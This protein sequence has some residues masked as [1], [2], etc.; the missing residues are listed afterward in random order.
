MQII[1]WGLGFVETISQKQSEAEEKA[2]H[3]TPI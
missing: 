3:P 2:Q 1:A